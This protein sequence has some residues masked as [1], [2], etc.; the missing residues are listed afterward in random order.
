MQGIAIGEMDPT[1]RPATPDLDDVFNLSDLLPDDDGSI[2]M[3]A[4]PENDPFGPVD[5]PDLD[6]PVDDMTMDAAV[7]DERLTTS[8]D[9]L[10]P[11]G[12]PDDDGFA[13]EDLGMD[14]LDLDDQPDADNPLGGTG[15][16]FVRLAFV[17]K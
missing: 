7:I 1:S 17:G 15:L 14:D 16:C 13:P 11:A 5:L 8:I 10:V 4:I 6:L 9:D 3:D 2:V 12:A